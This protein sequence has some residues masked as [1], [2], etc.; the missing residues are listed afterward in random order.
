MESSALVTR[1]RH[2]SLGVIGVSQVHLC[3]NRCHGVRVC[4]LFEAGQYPLC[5][6]RIVFIRSS[7]GLCTS[8]WTCRALCSLWPT[9]GGGLRPGQERRARSGWSW[10]SRQGHP[11]LCLSPRPPALLR[12]LA[13]PPA[14][15][16][17]PA[18]LGSTPTSRP[19]SGSC[20][21]GLGILRSPE[22]VWRAGERVDGSTFHHENKG[23]WGSW[24]S[25][26]SSPLGLPRA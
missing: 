12:P 3:P 17:M 22:D 23:R 15:L 24:G 8:S 13:G 20:W 6:C 25:L 4:L 1:C 10:C 19:V 9:P 5:A 7:F 2:L 18:A 21:W 11:H 14:S 16:R 26:D